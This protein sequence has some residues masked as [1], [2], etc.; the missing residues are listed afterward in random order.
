MI[1]LVIILLAAALHAARGEWR[2]DLLVYAAG[3]ALVAVHASA[4][5]V[6]PGAASAA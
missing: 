4:R 1:L 5:P 3:V 2:P 6:P